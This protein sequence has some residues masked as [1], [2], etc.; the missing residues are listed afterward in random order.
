MKKILVVCVALGIG[1]L[2]TNNTHAQKI[3]VF[4]EQSVLGLMP[5]IEKVDTVLNKYVND[6]LAGERD[7]ELSELKRKD[8]TFKKDSATMAASVRGIMQKE[9]AQHWYKL[10]NWQQYQ[11]QMVQ[12]KQDELYRPFLEKIVAALQE[13]VAEQKYSYVLRQDAFSPYAPPPLADNLTI[14]V[15]QKMGLKL[16]QNVLDALKAQGLSTGNP[17]KAVTPAPAKTPAKH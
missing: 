16:P 14:K 2:F 6:S 10:Q 12:Q 1:L 11:Q 8:S 7:Y 3:G 5:G 15:A 4:D 13:I 17:A 9:I